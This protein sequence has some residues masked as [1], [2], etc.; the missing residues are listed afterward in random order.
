MSERGPVAGAVLLSRRADATTGGPAGTAIGW[1]SMS[2]TEPQPLWQRLDEGVPATV[3]AKARRLLLAL[4]GAMVEGLAVPEIRATAAG[5]AAPGGHGP[6]GAEVALE[7]ASS[8]FVAALAT[9][10]VSPWTAAASVYAALVGAVIARDRPLGRLVEAFV[11]G[12]EAGAMAALARLDGRDAPAMTEAPARDRDTPLALAT[13]A[14]AA[15]MLDRAAAAGMLEAG[16][17]APVMRGGWSLLAIAVEDDA[18]LARSVERR[19]DGRVPLATG[20]RLVRQLLATGP[21]VPA[22]ALLC[23]RVDRAGGG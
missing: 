10:S 16:P 4:T 1:T 14:S 19:L 15:V 18:A 3:D 20:R 23:E 22:R 17:G 5:L 8:A 2:E 7:P 12:H 6:L 9:A 11:A 13:A 21:D